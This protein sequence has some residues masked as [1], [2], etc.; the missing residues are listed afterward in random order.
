MEEEERLTK[1][2]KRGRSR[3]GDK[4]LTSSIKVRR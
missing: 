3:K 4:G 2:K 1:E